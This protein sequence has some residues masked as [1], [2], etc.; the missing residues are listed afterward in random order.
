[1]YSRAISAAVEGGLSRSA[2]PR[3]AEEPMNR[4][5]LPAED[6]VRD[7]VAELASRRDLTFRDWSRALPRHPTVVLAT[8]RLLRERGEGEA[9]SLLDELLDGGWQGS[10]GGADD[11]RLLAARAEALGLRSHW[12]EAAKAYR[13]AIEGVDNDL[14][15]RSWWFNLAE[16]AQRLNDEGQRQ[17]AFRAVL[18]AHGSDDISRRV[19]KIQRAS[20]APAKPRAGFGSL[21]AN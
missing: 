17:A 10:P 18:A 11:P 4:Y 2:T 19:G 21:R 16:I 1:L 14:I 8:A 20:G 15:R 6:K 12:N 9:E 13:Q 3:F 5:F 7:I